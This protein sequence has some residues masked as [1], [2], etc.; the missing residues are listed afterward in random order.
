MFSCAEY[1]VLD[2]TLQAQLLWIDGIYL[3]ARNTE[4]LQVQMFSLYLFYVEVFY[5][6]ENEDPLYVKAFTETRHLDAYL[7]SIC[8]D[9]VFEYLRREE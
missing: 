7:D 9:A 5:D 3:M 8:I 6:R 2:E 4:C 1:G